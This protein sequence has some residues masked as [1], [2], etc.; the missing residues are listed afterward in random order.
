MPNSALSVFKYGTYRSTVEL[1]REEAGGTTPAAHALCPT[2]RT[3]AKWSMQSGSVRY[4][5]TTMDSAH[6]CTHLL[7]SKPIHNV[8]PEIADQ[9]ASTVANGHGITPWP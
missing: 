8:V 4:L 5:P 2:D 7:V 3:A 6:P 9:P 1:V